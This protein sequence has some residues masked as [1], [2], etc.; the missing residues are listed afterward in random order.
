MGL[1]CAESGAG[2]GIRTRDI[3]LGKVA[4]YQLSYSRAGNTCPFQRIKRAADPILT[5]R[6]GIVNS[7]RAAA[8][9]ASG[10]RFGTARHYRP[11]CAI[12]NIGF[13]RTCIPVGKSRETIRNANVLVFD[14][15]QNISRKL[16]KVRQFYF[17][18]FPLPL[19]VFCAILFSARE[20]RTPPLPGT[21][22]DAKGRFG[23]HKRVV[24][25][26]ET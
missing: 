17:W 22:A 15:R 12:V 4:L 26:P 7:A 16:L 6:F 1:G 20:R 18:K 10:T 11:A 14:N 23:A 24:A 9:R 21:M 3:N 19:T 8:T 2:D 13:T 25:S 5:R